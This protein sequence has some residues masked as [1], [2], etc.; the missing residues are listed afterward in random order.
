MTRR[1][2][3]VAG[4][5]AAWSLAAHAEQSTKI[6]RIGYLEAGRSS[7]PIPR[8]IA[9]AFRAGLRELGYVEGRNLTLELRW[10]DQNYDRLPDMVMDLVRLNVDVLT[11]VGTP[12]GL[13]RKESNFGNSNCC[14]LWR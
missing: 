11:V 8:E 9:D 1:E 4:S 3:I 7:D 10:A 14:V 13:S 12:P 5:V 6:P 2:F